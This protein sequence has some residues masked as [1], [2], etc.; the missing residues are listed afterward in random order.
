MSYTKIRVNYT[1]DGLNTKACVNTRKDVVKKATLPLP[2]KLQEYG[3]K[4]GYHSLSVTYSL[5]H[6]IIRGGGEEL[7]NL[8]INGTDNNEYIKRIVSYEWL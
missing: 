6:L 7:M 4:Y 1:T 2:K 3:N 8:D 5:D